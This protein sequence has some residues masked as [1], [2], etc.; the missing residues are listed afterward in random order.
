MHWNLPVASILSA[1]N[2]VTGGSWLVTKGSTITRPSTLTEKFCIY[3]WLVFYTCKRLCVWKE[4][5]L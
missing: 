1:K 4:I 3:M 5:Q 2:M